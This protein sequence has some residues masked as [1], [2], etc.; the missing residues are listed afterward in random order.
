M[1]KYYWLVFV[2][3]AI[4]GLLGCEQKKGID[5]TQKYYEIPSKENL[6]SL[7]TYFSTQENFNDPEFFPKF[8]LEFEK[9]NKGKEWEKSAQLLFYAGESMYVNRQSDSLMIQTYQNF[10]NEH[11]SEIS[12]RYR[13]GLMLNL[14][15]LYYYK[16][17]I[18]S[19][20]NI[21]TRATQ[22]QHHDYHTLVNVSTAYNELSYTFT[23]LGKYD[24]ALFSAFKALDGY[25]KLSDTLGIGGACDAISKVYIALEDYNNAEKYIDK[26]VETLMSGR[27]FSSVFEVYAGKLELYQLTD[28]PKLYPFVDTLYSFYQKENFQN[29]FYKI[30]AYGWKVSKFLEEKNIKEAGKMIAEILPIFNKSNEKFLYGKFI[31]SVS[32]FEKETG[33]QLINSDVYKDGLVEYKASKNPLGILACYNALMNVA[34]RKTDY[35]NAYLYSQEYNYLEDSLSS[36]NLIIKTKELDRKYQSEKKEQQILLQVTELNQKNTTIAL[37]AAVLGGIFIAIFA[38][39]L[40]NRQKKLKQE[41][42]NSMNFTK[43]LLQ[44]TEEERKRIAGDL[45]DS[46]SHELLNLKS[47]FTQDI[48]VVNSKIDTIINDIRGISRNLHPVM[49]DKIGLEPNIEALVERV[50]SHNNFFTSTDIQYSG[51]L[52]SA[53]ELQVYRIIQEALTNIIKYSK[54][55]AAKITILEKSTSIKIE[56]KDNGRGFNVKE[57]MNSSKAFGLHNIIERSRIIGGEASILS[58]AEGTTISTIIPKEI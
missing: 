32:I 53:D 41:K 5:N 17:S 1:I 34:L 40:W 27:Y 26:A 48:S 52:S 20:I 45:H 46:I 43:Q 10:L 58:N 23:E 3:F 6:N 7:A 51:S 25:T 15:I 57:T 28:N 49:F 30:T 38:F 13:S 50:Q 47:I 12:D 44:N 29:D 42:E 31:E 9:L 14:G 54:A 56:I 19:S 33:K 37:L 39:Y 24:K 35:K 18:D 36:K 16:S 22:I 55:H 2:G 4:A 8:Y 11:K 21:L